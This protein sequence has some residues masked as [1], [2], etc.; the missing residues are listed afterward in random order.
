MQKKW[1]L[2]IKNSRGAAD[3]FGSCLVD[4]DTGE[5]RISFVTTFGVHFCDWNSSPFLWASLATR[6][7]KLY[8]KINPL[9]NGLPLTSGTANWNQKWTIQID[10][11]TNHG[12]FLRITGFVQSIVQKCFVASN[13]SDCPFQ[14]GWSKTVRY[15]I[16]QF[17]VHFQFIHRNA[18]NHDVI[19][20]SFDEFQTTQFKVYFE[21]YRQIRLMLIMPDSYL[22]THQNYQSTLFIAIFFALIF[23]KQFFPIVFRMEFNLKFGKYERGCHLYR[24][25]VTISEISCVQQ[26]HWYQS[27]SALC[28][29]QWIG[30]IFDIFLIWIYA[31]KKNRF[32]LF[33]KI[34]SQS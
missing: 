12:H 3:G 10:A 32:F 22:S 29:N 33:E 27:N 19:C 20:A 7:R 31:R 18:L 11:W 30:A 25:V 13:A 26:K 9:H 1:K 4:C 23:V 21:L 24:N 16:G 14:I 17:A 8:R 2:P 28:L 5:C 15:Q 6:D 34:S